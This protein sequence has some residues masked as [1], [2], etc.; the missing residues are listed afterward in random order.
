MDWG[1]CLK[2]DKCEFAHPKM[3]RNMVNENY[4]SRSNCWFNHPNERR[5][6]Y[7]FGNEKHGQNYNHNQNQRGQ[8]RQDKQNMQGNPKAWQ[9]NNMDRH[10]YSNSAPFLAGPTPSEA[11][12]NPN[13]NMNMI[14]LMGDMFIEMSSK[15]MS[16]N[17]NY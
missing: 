7:V 15:I 4:C 14:K 3:C 6:L 10:Q 9:N 16:M 2:K 12:R 11:Y 8:K 5:N 13:R 1:K 17:M